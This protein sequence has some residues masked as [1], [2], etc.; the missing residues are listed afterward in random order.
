MSEKEVVVSDELPEP[1]GPYSPAIRAGGFVFVSGQGPIDPA[2][3][4]VV[5]G[6]LRQQTK[7]VLENVSAILGAA[8]SSL[9]KVVKTN[10]YLSDIGD[11]AAMNEVYATVFTTEPPA[12]TTIQAA[13]LPLGIDVEIDVIALAD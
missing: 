13:A 9:D 10:V 6:D 1:K 11:F 7:L 12:R 3:G 5:K 8:G 4:E 2:T